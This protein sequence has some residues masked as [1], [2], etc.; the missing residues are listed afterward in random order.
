MKEMMTYALDRLKDLRTERGELFH[1]KMEKFSAMAMSD[2]SGRLVDPLGVQVDPLRRSIFDRS[3]LSVQLPRNVVSFLHAKMDK[4]T[5]GSSPWLAVSPRGKKNPALAEQMQPHGEYKLEEAHWRDRARGAMKTVLDLGWVP[6]KTAW[7]IDEDISEEV[8]SV[9]FSDQHGQ[10]VTDERGDYLKPEDDTEEGE[11]PAPPP[12]MP[13][14]QA[15]APEAAPDDEGA[16]PPG[17]ADEQGEGEEAAPAAAP[18]FFSKAPHIPVP[19]GSNG[20]RFKDHLVQ[21]RERMYAGLDFS[22]LYWKDVCWPTNAASMT[23]DDPG[24]D[25]I[26]VTLAMTVEQIGQ[27]YDPDGKND[28]LQA[29]LERWRS[30]GNELSEGSKPKPELK[31]PPVKQTDPKNPTIKVTECYFRRRVM[32]TGPESRCFM[33]VA[34]SYPNA[35]IFVEYLK[36]MTPRAQAPVHLIAVNR[37]PGRAYGRGFYE[38]FEMASNALDELLNQLLVRNEFHSNPEK[39]LDARAAET[40]KD[41][42]Q[43]GPGTTNTIDGKGQPIRDLFHMIEMPDLDERTW[44]IFE[45]LIQLI[46]TESGVND[47]NQGNMSG[48]DQNNTAT[49]VNNALESS[50]VIHTFRLEEVRSG[51]TPPLRF[52]LELIYFKQDEDEPYDLLDGQDQALQQLYQAEEIV[53]EGP[54]EAPAPQPT[55]P[56]QPGV[57]T[58]AQ[59]QSLANVPL[60][61][62]ILLSRAKRQEQRQAAFDAYPYVSTFLKESPQDQKYLR[63]IVEQGLRNMD[64]RDSDDCLPTGAEIDAAIQAQQ[65]AAAAGQ[66]SPEE[67]ISLRE[68]MNYSD[69]PAS[70]QSQME[71]DAGFQP[72]SDAD[73]AAFAESQKKPDLANKPGASFPKPALTPAPAAAQ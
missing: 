51:L 23:L 69:V 38:L 18:R 7:R 28:E 55:A 36:H 24:C 4:D 67:R 63:P 68:N 42:I 14:A 10:P 17:M 54:Q 34:E 3:N 8:E 65:Q 43:I 58:Y 73:R 71:Q 64:I 31:E 6:V 46:Q 30:G 15:P 49:G 53:E 52:A 22:P 19:N 27:T 48:L 59:A 45:F 72:A 33:V 61:V 26:S 44:Q 20:L 2:F 5:F 35:P 21:T 39:Y 13:P 66:K 62:E 32:P 60:Q 57:M 47:I 25:F 50:S 1:E 11:P 70:I 12:S 40:M 37:V 16:E 9:L 29:M 56:N 41:G